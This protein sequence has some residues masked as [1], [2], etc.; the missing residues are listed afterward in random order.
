MTL[1]ATFNAVCFG[2]LYYFKQWFPPLNVIYTE[3]C[4]IMFVTGA[5]KMFRCFMFWSMKYLHCVTRWI[6]SSKI[7]LFYGFWKESD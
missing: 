4:G 7:L 2:K 6:V 1:H 5:P 3:Y